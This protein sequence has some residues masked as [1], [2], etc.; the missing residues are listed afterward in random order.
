MLAFVL[1]QGVLMVARN[2]VYTPVTPCIAWNMTAPA[3][4]RDSVFG[5]LDGFA[6]SNKFSFKMSWA[7]LPEHNLFGA[8]LVRNDIII[9]V[10]NVFDIEAY[11]LICVSKNRTPVHPDIVEE[12]EL[13]LRDALSK[14]PGIK[15]T[16]RL[17]DAARPD[18][19]QSR[20]V[21]ELVTP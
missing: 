11:S 20:G 5:A 4:E 14:V 10:A 3:A 17:A 19:K 9:T 12:L 18:D 16:D 13:K 1:Y 7:H 2:L 21:I 6:Q 15:I 8:D